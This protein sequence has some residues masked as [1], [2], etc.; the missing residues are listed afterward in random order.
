M[1]EK[2]V[3]WVENL[4]HGTFI[5]YVCE[6]GF[7]GLIDLLESTNIIISPNAQNMS[8]SQNKTFIVLDYGFIILQW[9]SQ[10]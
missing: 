6:W 9:K 1:S 8:R 7:P 3:V 2:K 4:I 5:N 10:F